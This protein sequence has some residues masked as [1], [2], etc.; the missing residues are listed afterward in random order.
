MIVPQVSDAAYADTETWVIRARARA[1]ARARKFG[2]IDESVGRADATRRL[3]PES[4][5]LIVPLVF[6]PLR[7]MKTRVVDR[8][9]LIVPQVSD[10]AYADTETWVIRA[11]ARA[12]ARARK[13][14]IIDES[15]GRADA[16]RRLG[17]ESELLIV[18]QVSDVAYA[19][20]ETWVI[21]ARARARARARKFGIMDKSVGLADATRRLG[22][23]SEL[24]IVPLLFML[25]RSMKNKALKCSKY[26]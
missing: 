17:P 9:L 5:L 16:T 11:R 14:G 13:F 20:T 25:L 24:L 10:A 12:R 21:R 7:G 22:P 15:V 19:N 4:E 1:R 6:M 2:I 3:G 26:I 8:N 23:E 18:P